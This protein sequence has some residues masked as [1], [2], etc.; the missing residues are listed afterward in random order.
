[1]TYLPSRLFSR[2]ENWREQRS[3]GPNNNNRRGGGNNPRQNQYSATN[4]RQQYNTRIA[5]NNRLPDTR[6]SYEGRDPTMQH[7]NED[8]NRTQRVNSGNFSQDQ[9]SGPSSPSTTIP[10]RTIYPSGHRPPANRN[11]PAPYADSSSSRNN[12]IPTISPPPNQQPGPNKL[13]KKSSN[14]KNDCA[15][16]SY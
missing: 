4:T 16:L 7:P 14:S 1:M 5:R 8:S 10:A 2:R 12:S 11:S 15:A 3:T 6:S 9:P 13:S